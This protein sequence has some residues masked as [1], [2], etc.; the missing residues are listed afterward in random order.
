MGL[1]FLNGLNL[2]DWFM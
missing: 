1:I 2:F